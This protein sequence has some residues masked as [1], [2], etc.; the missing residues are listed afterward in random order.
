[1][2][3]R[4]AEKPGLDRGPCRVATAGW[5]RHEGEAATA[6]D[7]LVL[8]TTATDRPNH[9]RSDLP[10][11]RPPRL[12]LRS[13]DRVFP[14]PKRQPSRRAVR[15]PA[16]LTDVH[17]QLGTGRATRQRVPES[18]PS[19]GTS[20]PWEAHPPLAPPWLR[21]APHRQRP[22]RRLR[23]PPARA[24]QPEHYPR[25]LRPPLRPRRPRPDREHALEASYA[26]TTGTDG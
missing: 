10:L 9:A 14:T 17:Q 23:Q 11:R 6:A 25:G 21:L 20:G 2:P 5:R 1:M 8:A 7:E 15:A 3:V 24:R 4:C 26:T 16:K 13:A 18:H 22:Q 19:R 12:H